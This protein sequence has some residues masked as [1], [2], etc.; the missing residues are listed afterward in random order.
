[1]P[2]AR[3][4]LIEELW[5]RRS[6]ICADCLAGAAQIEPNAVIAVS[7]D[8][9]FRRLFDRGAGVCPECQTP[10]LLLYPPVRR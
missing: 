4:R 7:E 6:P 10:K 1:M 9:L 3:Q 2:D 8:E 5:K